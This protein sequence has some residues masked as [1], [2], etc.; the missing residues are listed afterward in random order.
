MTLRYPC[1]ANNPKSPEMPVVFVVD[2]APSVRDARDVPLRSAEC[3][4]KTACCRDF[5]RRPLTAALSG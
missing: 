4:P 2:G 5:E 3:Q 1:P